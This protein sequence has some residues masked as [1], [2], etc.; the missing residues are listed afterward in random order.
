MSR[1]S[2]ACFALALGCSNPPSGTGGSG[3]DNSGPCEDGAIKCRGVDLV[4]VC[5]D[6][7]WQTDR[8]CDEGQ[9]CNDGA[10]ED[11]TCSPG[12]QRCSTGRRQVCADD[13]ATWQPDPCPE[14]TVCTSGGQCG[15]ANCAP[16]AYRCADVEG[17]RWP[18][19]TLN[20][21]TAVSPRSTVCGT[22]LSAR[23]TDRTLRAWIGL[24][25]GF[26][27][28]ANLAAPG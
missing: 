8:R 13:E 22:A 6:A 27:I 24:P 7:A 16:G 18:A 10:C 14:G 5:V 3:A 1:L 17:Q 19:L 26:I 20:V 21:R 15:S 25:S 11:G 2:I 9:V 28:G 23:C 12:T 4:Q